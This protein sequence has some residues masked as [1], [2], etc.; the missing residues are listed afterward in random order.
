MSFWYKR[1]ESQRRFTVYWCSVLIATASGGLLASAIANMDGTRGL[2]DWRWIFILEGIMTIFIG[3]ISFF[4]VSDFPEDVS[5]LSEEERKFVI[6][7]AEPNKEQ[8]RDIIFHD[9]LR[10]VTDFKNIVG[11]LMYFCESLTRFLSESSKYADKKFHSCS[12]IQL[13]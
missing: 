9:I 6:A 5:W 4:L 8:R 7:R 13:L 11:G 12:Y 1:E 2:S 10:F 3:I